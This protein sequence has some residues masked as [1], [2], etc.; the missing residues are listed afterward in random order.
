M[1][2]WKRKKLCLEQEAGRVY[3][4][5]KSFIESYKRYTKKSRTKSNAVGYITP[6]MDQYSMNGQMGDTDPFSDM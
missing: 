1:T 2:Y 6:T 3:M 4:Q 5:K